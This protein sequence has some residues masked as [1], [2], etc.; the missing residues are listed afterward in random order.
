VIVADEA[1]AP[2]DGI[3]PT[4]LLHTAPGLSECFLVAQTPRGLPMSSLIADFFTP[5]GIPLIALSRLPTP[6]IFLDPAWDAHSADVAAP[7]VYAHTREN[8]AAFLPVFT[9]LLLDSGRTA[10]ASRPDG[11]YA[12]ALAHWAFQVGR[13]VLVP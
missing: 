2:R 8:S 12:A 11:L 13:G 10:S 3:P 7:A 6:D 1:V 9:G 4:A 5:N